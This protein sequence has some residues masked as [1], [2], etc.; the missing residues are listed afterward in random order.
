M[1]AATASSLVVIHQGAI[2]DFILALSVV[3]AAAASLRPGRVIA[4]ASAPS[5]AVAAGRSVI[6]EHRSPD[7][8]GLHTLFAENGDL[9]RR[10][11]DILRPAGWILSFLGPQCGAIHER[12]RAATAGRVISL[13]P[14]PSDATLRQRRH[15]TSQWHETVRQSGL[16]IAEP[17]PPV[18]RLGATPRKPRDVPL[19][20]LIHPGSGGRAK[21]WPVERFIALADRLNDCRVSWMLGPAETDRETA[22]ASAIR[23]R[24]A[25]HREPVIVEHDLTQAAGHIAKADLY[26]ANDAGITHLAAALGVPTVVVFGP[27]DPAVWRPLGHHVAVVAPPRPGLPIDTLDPDAVFAALRAHLIHT[28]H[29]P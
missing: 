26:L 9:D 22:T 10:L 2:G 28:T 12:L 8:V 7:A 15:I 27:T 24:S 17:Q 18:I 14:R 23:R 29:R 3:Q 6:D 21:C 1:Q 16:D 13:D 5:A 19:H 20:V 25:T 11:R 4:V